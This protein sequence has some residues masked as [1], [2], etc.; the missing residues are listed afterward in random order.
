M[1]LQAFMES[2]LKNNVENSFRT[3]FSIFLE[4]SKE[5]QI[6]ITCDNIITIGIDIF[7]SISKLSIF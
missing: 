2:L 3:Q 5:L 4:N 1:I 6:Y 7:C